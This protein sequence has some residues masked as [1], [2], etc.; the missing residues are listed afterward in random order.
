M[1]ETNTPEIVEMIKAGGG[2]PA[3]LASSPAT[4]S[5]GR[6]NG[7]GHV[8]A[9]P[10]VVAALHASHRNGAVCAVEDD[11]YLVFLPLMMRQ[12]EPRPILS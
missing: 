12:P 8:P 9:G 4:G 11:D 7:G 6:E 10:P 1:S 2:Q 3:S 5:E